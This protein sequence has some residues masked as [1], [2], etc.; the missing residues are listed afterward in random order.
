[1][2]TIAFYYSPK[3][4]EHHPGRGHPEESDRLQAVLA[5]LPELPLTRIE[6]E[7]VPRSQLLAVHSEAHLAGLEAVHARGGGALDPD[8]AMSAG[9]WPAALLAAG[10]AAQAVE[11]VLSHAGPRRAFCAVRPP[12]HHATR[13]RAMGFCLLNNVA[14]AAARA[15]TLGLSRVAIVDFDV[16][17]GNGT[18]EIFYEEGRV[19][20]VSTHQYPYYPGTGAARETG[21]G[22]GAG[23]TLNLPLPAGAADAA[24]REVLA[25]ALLPALEAFAPELLL[26]SAGFDAH[27]ADPLGGLALTTSMFG[28]LTRALVGVA[29]RY[30]AGAVVSCLEGGYDRPALG[31]CVAAH[32][33]AL[34]GAG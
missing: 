24:Y 32:L 8:T 19:L 25:N 27:E 31:A 29:E 3:F 16:H 4:L 17:H 12:G 30:A 6:P 10:A 23:K 9:S 7:P 15:L 11:L 1:M 33:A 18:Q 26:L 5:R 22:A 13:E 2:E 14:V 28:E 21:L 34:A 20:Y